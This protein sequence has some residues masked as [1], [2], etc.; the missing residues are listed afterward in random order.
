MARDRKAHGCGKL[1]LQHQRRKGLCKGI[2]KKLLK[3]IDVDEVQSSGVLF[4]RCQDLRKAK[5][6]RFRALREFSGRVYTKNACIAICKRLMM[7]LSPA[8]DPQKSFDTVATEQ[9]SRLQKLAKRTKSLPRAPAMDE[10]ET[11]PLAAKIGLEPFN[12]LL[13]GGLCVLKV[14]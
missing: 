13:F 7:E 4:P 3:V 12:F 11:Q 9:A 1:A 5:N 14:F 2:V 10:T 8:R 6:R